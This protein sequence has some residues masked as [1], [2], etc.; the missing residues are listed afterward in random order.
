MITGELKS[1]I[2]K[3]WEEFWTGGIANPLTVIEQI[4]FLMYAR[5]LDMNER[6][7]ELR[8][9]RS[10][11][12]FKRRFSE[13]QQEIRWERFRHLP[14]EQMY[15]RVKDEVFPHFKDLA[16]EGTLFAEFMKD[17][18][19][20]IQKPSLL[21]KAVNMISELPLDSA[22]VKGDLYEY[23]LSKLTTA[24]INGQFRTPRH[25]IRAI[26]E[27]LDP[28]A[29]SRIADP[30]CGTAGFLATSYEYLLEKYS[31]PDGVITE[32]AINEKGE[33]VEQKIYL[34]DLLHEHR[35]H[36]DRDMFHGFDFDSTMLRIAAMNLV[37]HGIA[38]PDIHYQ[39]TLSQRFSERFPKAANEAFDVILANPPF[40]GS[41]DE[42]DVDPALLRVVKTKKTELLFV[43]LIMRMLKTGGRAAII[44]PDGVLFGSSKAHQQLR[45]HLVEDNQ[46]EAVISLPS[47]VFKPYA[48]VSTAILIATKGGETDDVWF[49]NVEEDG[50]S[51]DDKRQPKAEN[52][53]PDLVRQFISRNN[54]SEGR[55]ENN[56]TKKHFWVSHN[57]I[58]ENKYDLSISRYKERT[59][60]IEE[61]EPPKELL[62]RLK[63]LE[64]DIEKDLQALEGML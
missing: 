23:L 47:G 49:Y 4:T 1:K 22:D 55:K 15:K 48:G 40:K 61:H 44:V 9:E 39:D 7:D 56:K 64:N 19:L 58:K 33:E 57:E 30:A 53:L 17:A 38:E 8:A 20:M 52:D 26:V 37:M 2:D 13:S 18:Q 12:S 32:T 29:T 36:V 63:A 25:I 14:A 5:M 6:R 50:R 11:K 3:L 24:G 59:Y 31:S 62:D 60:E 10:G 54:A 27:M 45:K 43:A 34:G 28:D 46:L 21:V 16:G 41:L 42:E 35:A 51:L